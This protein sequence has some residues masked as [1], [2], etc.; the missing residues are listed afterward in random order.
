MLHDGAK[1][2][3]RRSHLLLKAA[4]AILLRGADPG[5]NLWRQATWVEIDV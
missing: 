1:S 2:G 4:K 3:T 5:A